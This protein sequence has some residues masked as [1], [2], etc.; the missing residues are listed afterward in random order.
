M[1]QQPQKSC[2]FEPDLLRVLLSW[3]PSPPSQSV[4]TLY[5]PLVDV[6]LNNQ[7]NVSSLYILST[8]RWCQS[9]QSNWSC[10]Q[11]SPVFTSFYQFLPVF[12]SHWVILS[13]ICPLSPSVWD[14]NSLCCQHVAIPVVK[15]DSHWTVSQHSVNGA[16][17]ELH[18]SRRTHCL[19]GGR[20]HTL[21]KPPQ[22]QAI[23]HQYG[24][25]LP[26]FRF[27][28]YYYFLIW[29]HHSGF[30]LTSCCSSPTVL[31]FED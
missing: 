12:T 4:W 19:L 21:R 29:G 24:F 5:C 23:K 3:P 10:R 31:G 2:C 26:L 18:Q 14:W 13:S 28:Y 9:R 1:T 15:Q 16:T 20:G 30:L 7:V 27:F 22:S 25:L 17:G 11:F 8:V 6:L